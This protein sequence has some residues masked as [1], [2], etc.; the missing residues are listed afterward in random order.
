M[1]EL[2]K[3]GIWMKQWLM[4]QNYVALNTTFRNVPEKQSTFRSASGKDK[5]L[6]Y[7]LFD[8]RNR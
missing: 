8:R 5:Q 3:R 1:G 7:V 4:I 6:D 2:N